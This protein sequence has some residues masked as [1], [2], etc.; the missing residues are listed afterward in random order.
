MLH[1]SFLFS[2]FNY[3]L[4][5][6]HFCSAPALSQKKEEMQEYGLELFSNDNYSSYN[7]LLLKAE[8]PTM[9]VNSLWKLAI[10]VF[11]TIKSSNPGFMH[12]YFKE[13]SRSA[14]RKND[15]VVNRAKIRTF[16]E[17]SLRTLGPNIW[18]SVPETSK[19]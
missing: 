1:D 7:S 12:T 11:K 3:Y 8:R 17:K 2:N 6:W 5:V 13:G 18:H 10:E 4:L 9:E 16:G 14:G 19:T 15:L